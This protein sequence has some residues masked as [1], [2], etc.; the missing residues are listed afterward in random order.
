MSNIIRSLVQ[1]SLAYL[2]RLMQGQ[3]KAAF[4]IEESKQIAELREEANHLEQSGHPDLANALRR[5]A[6][7]M[8]GNLSELSD[9]VP[10]PLG[11]APLDVKAQIVM[12]SNVL[13]DMQND[14]SS[15]LLK[16]RGR[17]KK[18]EGS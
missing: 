16:K 10:V 15:S 7:A 4:L 6:D 17:P 14:N 3:V 12:A 11:D 2:V 18:S 8:T 9:D 1:G 13:P 5:Q